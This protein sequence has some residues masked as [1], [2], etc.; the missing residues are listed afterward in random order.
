MLEDR[1]NRRGDLADG[2]RR[3]PR[4][5]RRWAEGQVEGRQIVSRLPLWRRGVSPRDEQPKPDGAEAPR[6][7]PQRGPGR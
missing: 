5:H 3:A 1:C 2:P 7:G 6:R 4:V